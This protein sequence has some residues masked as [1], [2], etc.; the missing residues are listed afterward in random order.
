MSDRDRI[1]EII[2]DLGIS[3]A[4]LAKELKP[5]S[6]PQWIYDIQNGKT[7]IS[8]EVS[9]SIVEIWPEYNIAWVCFG[10]G[11]KY[12][13]TQVETPSISKG[14]EKLIANISLERLAADHQ[15]MREQLRHIEDLILGIKL[16]LGKKEGSSKSL[17][18]GN[19]APLTKES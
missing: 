11:D 2:S 16:E 1:N 10:M 4:N 3:A 5:N 7:G 9:K 14:K 12:N 17:N 6:R 19:S 13:I 15:L 8:K 18:T